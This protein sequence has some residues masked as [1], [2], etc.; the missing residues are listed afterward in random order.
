LGSKKLSNIDKKILTKHLDYLVQQLYNK[1]C[2][3][4]V[5]IQT[6]ESEKNFNITKYNKQKYLLLICTVLIYVIILLAS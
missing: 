6:M 5:I 3:N 2:L 4:L 1:N